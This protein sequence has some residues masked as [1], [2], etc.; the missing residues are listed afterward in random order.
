MAEQRPSVDRNE[1][2]PRMRDSGTTYRLTLAALIKDLSARSSDT[3]ADAEKRLGDLG[4]RAAIPA[5]QARLKDR[6]V[7]V[8]M[9][10]L[11]ALGKLQAIRTKDLVDGLKDNNEL[12][13]VQAAEEI[14]RAGDRRAAGPL[15]RALT[16]PSALVRSYAAT[17]LGTVGSVSDRTKLQ[18]HLSE[19]TSDAARLGFYEGLWLLGVRTLFK[20][21]LQL[22]DSS[23]YRTR[24]ATAHV[25][26]DTFLSARTRNQILTALRKR[27][28]VEQTVAAKSSIRS[29]MKSLMRE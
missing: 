28:V 21:V 29:A 10:A 2:G 23:D 14:A 22:L 17:A 25:L 15:R 8:R 12:V 16:D 26:V 11:E 6:A 5:L 3:R 13:R 20:D 9:H 24:C 27:L 4:D 19:E 7:L 18:R 1:G